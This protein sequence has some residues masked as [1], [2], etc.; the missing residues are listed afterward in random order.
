MTD[1]FTRVARSALGLTPRVRVL[2]ATRYAPTPEVPE[3]QT[4]LVI[5]EVPRRAV[6]TSSRA[7]ASRAVASR[8]ETRRVEPKRITQSVAETTMP[9][10]V[11]QTLLSVPVPKEQEPP[12]QTG[13]SVLQADGARASRPQPASVPLAGHEAEA[14]DEH[15]AENENQVAG[16]DGRR[17]RTG[18]PRSSEPSEVEVIESRVESR[19]REVE[20]V[21]VTQ[22]PE[23][24]QAPVVHV[25]I[26]RVEV[27]AATPPPPQPPA[28]PPAPP[29]PRI[30]LDDY[31]RA[32]NG[33][34]R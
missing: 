32:H 18:R 20:R 21:L 9:E 7:I 16:R 17:L 31:L 6:S 5:D 14:A 29:T 8:S 23:P 22:K 25:T 12:A 13:V 24:E 11:A 26:G 19:T 15:V 2:A 4:P 28:E 34:T 33:R 30:S 10:P 27:R 3:A 1:F